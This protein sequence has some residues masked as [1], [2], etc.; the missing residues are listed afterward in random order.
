MKKKLKFFLLTALALI[1]IGG[2]Y[3]LYIFQFKEYEVADEEVDQI[4]EDPYDIELPD[5]TKLILEGNGNSDEKK[6]SAN[7]NGN[8]GNQQSTDVSS[9]GAVAGTTTDGKEQ[10]DGKTS[11]DAQTPVGGSAEKP[12]ADKGIGTI[13]KPGEKATVASIKGNYEP[14]LNNLQGQVDGKINSLI[15][16]AKS[17]YSSKKANGESIDYGYFYNKYMSAAKSLEAQ[18]DAVFDGVVRALERDLQANGY[19]K[20]YAQ[21]VRD[22]YAATKKA[23]RESIL[24]KA[25]GR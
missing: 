12:S 15:G 17:E 1:V 4:I 14:T 8:S 13:A 19:D 25:V 10:P 20:S 6:S 18:T 11:V 16:R 24:S 21:S 5:G 23:R 9:S 7:G 22:E 2:G 3:I